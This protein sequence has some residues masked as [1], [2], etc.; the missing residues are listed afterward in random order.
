MTQ[1]RPTTVPDKASR[2]KVLLGT[3]LGH[4]IEWYD[5]GIFAIFVP[6]FAT[7][8]FN[9]ADPVSAVLSSLAVFAVGFL[10]RPL[11]GF[12]FGW[13]ADHVG[14]KPALALTVGGMA[15]G[16]LVIGLAPTYE[17]IGVW[18]SLI[19]LSSRIIQGLACGG[20]L[21]SAQTYLSEMAPA[22]RRGRWSSLIYIASAGGNMVGILV[23]VILTTILSQ[24]EMTEFGWRIPFL[25]GGV[26]GLFTLYIRS[27][28]PETEMFESEPDSA[29]A[30]TKPRLW[31]EI[32]RHRRQALQVVGMTVGLTVVYYAWVIAA[33]AYAIS[34]LGIDESGALWAGVASSLI[35]MSVMPLWGMLSDRIGRKPV[36]LI[37][38]V[39]VA[40]TLF[41]L[42]ALVQDSAW[43]LFAAM[44]TAMIFIAAS[45]S[46]LPA[47]YAELFPTRIRTL[48]LA[49]PYS[50]SVAIFG[51]TAPYLQVWVGDNFGRSAFTGYIV[52]LL[53]ISAL[54]I[55]SLPETKGKRLE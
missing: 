23:G 21:P 17:A 32:V 26:F 50:I 16:S 43:Q 38:T 24:T 7:Q 40:V 29:Q 19:L 39:G 47:T 12:F 20:E 25:L 15:L 36:L 8:F 9:S 42:Q 35:F 48:G 37:G 10:A 55:T 27:Q 52:V 2:R 18:A 6:F 44:T 34:S 13:L 41:P 30:T 46:I 53:V 45:V 14:R 33:P 22:E 1:T 3:S 31:P 51:G 5:W 54:V 11:G 4:A 28:M 49:V